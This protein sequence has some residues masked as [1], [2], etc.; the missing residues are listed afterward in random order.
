MEQHKRHAVR[1]LLR[2]SGR[3]LVESWRTEDAYQD[4]GSEWRGEH[5]ERFLQVMVTD[6]C[7]LLE[8][9]R[10]AKVA[11]AGGGYAES[12]PVFGRHGAMYMV[13][14]VCRDMLIIDNQ[15]PLLVLEKLLAVESGN[16]LVIGDGWPDEGDASGGGPAAAPVRALRDAATG[17][18]RRRLGW[19]GDSAGACA[20][21]RR[22]GGWRLGGLA[23]WDGKG[24]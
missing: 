24:R 4:L 16:Q 8:M 5:R 22:P 7:F 9:M 21:R 14:H 10:P 11:G 12:D 2:R 23:G 19:R 3:K 6:G 18:A 1:Q 17:E 13:P 20:P 15:L